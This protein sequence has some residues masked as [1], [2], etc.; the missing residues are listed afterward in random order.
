MQEPAVPV[1]VAMDID[2]VA[3]VNVTVPEVQIVEPAPKR[4]KPFS[5]NSWRYSASPATPT[6]AATPATP[7]PAATPAT[8]VPAATPATPAP[9]APHRVSK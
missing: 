6:P 2:F 3:V 4:V 5:F 9:A 1:V 8:P 7:A